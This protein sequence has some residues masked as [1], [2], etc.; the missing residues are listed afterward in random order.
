MKK[1]L[2]RFLLLIILTAS[3]SIARAAYFRFMPYTVQQP[4]GEVISCFVSGDEYFNWLHDAA[5]YTIIQAPDGYYY[6]GIENNGLVI[7]S[8]YKVNTVN[9]SDAG[10]DKWAKIST[11]NYLK[12]KAFMNSPAAKSA[13]GPQTGTLNNIV[14]YI[15][16]SDDTEFTVTRASYDNKFNAPGSVSLYNYF[17]EVSYNQLSI[18]STHYPVAHS[19]PIYLSR[20][21]TRVVITSPITLLQIPMGMPTTMNANSGNIPCWSMQ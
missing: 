20:T 21:L 16:F 11:E 1:Y 13:K 10:L 17:K 18:V 6:Y 8:S 9:P 4:G 14:I 5:G 3:F 12:K 7:P 15:R 19:Q 2:F